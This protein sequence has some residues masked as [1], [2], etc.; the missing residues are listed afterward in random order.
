MSTPA[1]VLPRAVIVAL[2]VTAASCAPRAAAK[3][4]PAPTASS[5][6]EVVSEAPVRGRLVVGWRTAEEQREVEAGELTLAL[7]RRM[8]ERWEPGDDVDFAKTQRVRV[9]LPAG[10]PPGA[11]PVAI[12]DVDHT[13]WATWT[14]GGRGLV[15]DGRDRS[16][17]VRLAANPSAAPRKERCAGDRYRLITI[18]APDVPGSPRR[19]CAWL[20]RSWATSPARRYPIVLLL[21]GVFSADTSYLRGKGH[22]GE[23]LDALALAPT[24]APT[25]DGHG[26]QN[27]RLEVAL[28]YVLERLDPAE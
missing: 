11:V 2:A 3:A 22:L 15:G 19:F 18:D 5:S 28:R 23:R 27:P 16:G 20:P 21:P 6:F 24:F 25:D 13:F 17:V 14:G 12:L 7:V 8:I 9:P 26:D 4:V 1:E 10:A